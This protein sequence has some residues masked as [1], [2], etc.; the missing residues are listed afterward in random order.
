MHV[1]AMLPFILVAAG[2]ALLVLRGDATP[3]RHA[4]IRPPDLEPPTL[5]GRGPAPAPRRSLA[6]NQNVAALLANV[7]V[8]RDRAASA[9]RPQLTR[10]EAHVRAHP[11]VALAIV[12]GIALVVMLLAILAQ[13]REAP[14]NATAQPT[15]RGAAA[16]AAAAKTS[17]AA[18]AA[19]S[20]S[21]AAASTPPVA[22]SGAPLTG[23]GLIAAW[24]ATGLKVEAADQI[25]ACGATKPRAYRANGSQ[26]AMVFVYPSPPALSADWAVERGAPL[27]FRTSGCLPTGAV[28]YWN[29]NIVLSF[30]QLTDMGV[31]QQMSDALLRMAV[32]R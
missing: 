26:V 27:A 17:G 21:P 6:F 7:R 14:P 30:P 12:G 4:S 10:T 8:A 5:P 20:T 3:R 22:D 16:T 23:D 18:P 15:N 11:S 29:Q 19:S 2:I 32:P 24:I 13:P 25:A 28:T 9:A 1:V 31:K